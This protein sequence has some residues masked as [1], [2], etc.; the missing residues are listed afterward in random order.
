MT[1]KQKVTMASVILRRFGFTNREAARFWG[2]REETVAKWVT[3]ETDMP[4]T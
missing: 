2:V 1:D 4:T 3:G